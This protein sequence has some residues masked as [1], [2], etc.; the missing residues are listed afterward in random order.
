[1]IFGDPQWLYHPVRAI[2]LLCTMFETFTRKMFVP[3]GIRFCGILT[4]LLVTGSSALILVVLFY[5]LTE[6]NSFLSA[7]AAVILLYL[8]IAAGDLMAHSN[9]VYGSLAKEDIIQARL[10]VAMLVGRQ[11]E[12]MDKNEIS[13]AC[14]ESVAEN[15]VDG[16]TAPLFWAV[17]FSTFFGGLFFDPI[18]WAALERLNREVPALECSQDTNR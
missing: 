17:F 9:R 1:M 8:S 7:L 4:F 3:L 6:L 12:N 18:I 10:E 15:M 13:R 14:I 16:I 5:F 2:G 11:T